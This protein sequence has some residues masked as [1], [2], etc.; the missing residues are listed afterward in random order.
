MGLSE[1]AMLIGRGA[2][3]IRTQPHL[4][5]D[6]WRKSSY[7]VAVGECVGVETAVTTVMVRDSQYSKRASL[8]CSMAFWPASIERVTTAA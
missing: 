2:P 3:M 5:R 6:D 1:R 7:S 8:I 4:G